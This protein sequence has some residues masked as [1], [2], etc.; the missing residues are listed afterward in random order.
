MFCFVDAQALL[1][2]RFLVVLA[3]EQ[4]VLV[5]ARDA[6]DSRHVGWRAEDVE[7]LVAQRAGA[8]AGDAAHQLLGADVE[9]H[10]GIDGS[11]EFLRQDREAFGLRLRARE[12]IEDES[13]P[14]VGLHDAVADDV[15]H[16]GIVDQL[17]GGHDGIGAPAEVGAFLA[18]LPE[19]VAGGDLRNAETRDETLCLGALARSGRA[20]ENDAHVR[21]LT[22]D[23]PP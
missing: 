7:Y 20:H 4:L 23:L 9:Q 13:G 2:G 14:C 15:E 16:G 22:C 17:A 5:A 3:L 11:A 1:H 6:I 10:D 19:D 12:P 8:P 21:F 18:M